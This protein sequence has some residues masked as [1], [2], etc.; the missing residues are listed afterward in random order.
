MDP[1]L[2]KY[3][4]DY[5]FY[6]KIDNKLKDIKLNDTQEKSLY[7]FAGNPYTSSYDRSKLNEEFDTDYKKLNTTEYTKNKNIAR[8]L[9]KLQLIDYDKIIQEKSSHMKKCYYVTELGIYYI[10]KRSIFLKINI[11]SMIKNFPNLKILEDL[12]YPF[13]KKE[14]I[15]SSN[16]PIS[17]LIL[18]SSYVQK[19]YL[20]IEKFILYA[21]NKKDWEEE[22]LIVIVDEY[23]LK[24]YLQNYLN[25][26][27]KDK[28]QWLETA[29]TEQNEDD[30]TIIK[31]VNIDQPLEYLKV[32]LL[33]DRIVILLINGTKKEKKPKKIPNNIPN[34]FQY[35]KL[36]FSSREERINSSFSN[37]YS[38]GYL[39]FISS[40]LPVLK[41]LDYKTATLFL[42]DK[43]FIRSLNKTK[44]E[45][46][47]I[48][49]S[50]NNPSKYSREAQMRSFVIEFIQQQ[51]QKLLDKNN[52][53]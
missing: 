25:K 31:F 20:E 17:I 50:I 16:F 44:K 30:N 13:I 42:Q 53:K 28:Y 6:L 32:Q 24:N 52:F 35:E 51:A 40:I 4:S 27:Y 1:Y 41:T 15:C 39:E 36:K 43:N 29:H 45:F 12:L 49:K 33:K 11:Q 22:R 8:Q 19:Q 21:E 3:Y 2:L 10:M 48:Y 38:L 26:R 9:C 5:E 23:K 34:I 14:T 47:N 18:I 7:Y 37:W 46:E